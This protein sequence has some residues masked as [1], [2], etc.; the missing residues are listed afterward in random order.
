[1][2][3]Q[4]RAGSGEVHGLVDFVLFFGVFLLGDHVHQFHQID[5]LTVNH[6]VTL[7]VIKELLNTFGD[8]KLNAFASMEGGFFFMN[9][10]VKSRMSQVQNLVV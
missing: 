1:M 8:K 5:F 6:F 9:L 10:G 2:D 7:V 4:K 3:V